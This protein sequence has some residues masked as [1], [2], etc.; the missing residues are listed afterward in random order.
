MSSLAILI[1]LAGGIDALQGQGDFDEFLTEGG[2]SGDLLPV[3]YVAL[4]PDC[5]HALSGCNTFRTATA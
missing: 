5:N 4:Q 1:S 3:Y 2:H